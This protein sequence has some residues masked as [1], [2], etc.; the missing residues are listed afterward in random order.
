MPIT[1]ALIGKTTPIW[2]RMSQDI[3]PICG[4][5]KIRHACRTKSITGSPPLLS[6]Y[7]QPQAQC[8]S[9]G[10]APDPSGIDRRRITAAVVNCKYANAHGGLNGKKTLIVGG[11]IDVFLVEPSID[12]SR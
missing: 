7:G 5:P 4:K 9:P 3:K 8:L 11:Y 10:L 6:A 12:R 1:R 2:D